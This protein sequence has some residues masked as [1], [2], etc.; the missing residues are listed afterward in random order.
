[1]V[2][3][4][5]ADGNG[6]STPTLDQVKRAAEEY[7]AIA[8]VAAKAGMQQGLH[9]EGFETSRSSTASG[10]TTCCSTCSTRSW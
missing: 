3:A 5:L 6:G 7:N 4:T 8:A 2:T 9:N 1:M 10:P